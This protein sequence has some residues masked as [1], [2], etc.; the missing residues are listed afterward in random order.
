MLILQIGTQTVI[1][2]TVEEELCESSRLTVAVNRAGNFCGIHKEG[3]SGLDPSSLSQ[4][5]SDARRIGQSILEKLFQALQLEET[6]GRRE[7]IGFFSA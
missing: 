7:K 6:T 1:D 2:A 5:L 3:L 4:M